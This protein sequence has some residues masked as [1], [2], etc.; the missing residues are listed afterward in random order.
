MIVYFNCT[1]I[2]GSFKKLIG[3]PCNTRMASA[4]LRKYKMNECIT[5]HAM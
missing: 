4:K 3:H 2:L 1:E 5:I